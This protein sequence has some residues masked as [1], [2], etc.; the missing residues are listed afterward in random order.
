MNCALYI[1]YLLTCC[2]VSETASITPFYVTVS[3]SV[4]V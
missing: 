1:L 4:T 3:L 2:I